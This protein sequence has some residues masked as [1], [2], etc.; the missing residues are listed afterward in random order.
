MRKF[1][2]L[3]AAAL[4][5]SSCLNEDG[6]LSQFPP[7]LAIQWLCE[8][9]NEEESWI[10]LWDFASRKGYVTFVYFDSLESM[11]TFPQY[12]AED[13]YFFAYKC[14]RRGDIYTLTLDDADNSKYYFSDITSKSMIATAEDGYQ[15]TLQ[16]CPL[17][18]SAIAIDY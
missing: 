2:Y 16:P 12:Y 4:V 14:Y 17:K 3:I 1:F 13:K 15:W 8:E 5:L 10:T 9:S 18:I 6:M 11:K 7:S